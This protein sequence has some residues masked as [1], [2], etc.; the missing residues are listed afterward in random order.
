MEFY[1]KRSYRG[2]LKAVIVD[3]AGTTV[4]YGCCAPAKVFFE[5]FKEMGVNV[6]MEEARLHMGRHKRDHIRAI[7]DIPRIKD[8]WQS[9]YHR[10]PNESDVSSMFDRFLPLQL[11][12]LKNHSKLI[13][14]V[15]EAVSF[16]RKHKMKIGSTTGYTKKMMEIVASEA[17]AQGYEPDFIVCSDEVPEGRPAPYM[18]FENAKNLSIY[19]MESMVKIGDTPVDIEEGQNAN[20]WTIGLARTGNEL[21]CSEEEVEALSLEERNQ[22]LKL[23]KATLVKSGAHYVVDSISDCIPIIEQINFRLSS[24]EKP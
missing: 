4:D 18:C 21:G 11:S 13:P 24:G 10:P 1:F 8:L 19:P 9:R 23:A 3:W 16:F 15:L 14:R 17:K 20:M 6:T 22:K 7:M 5:V 12:T 2:C